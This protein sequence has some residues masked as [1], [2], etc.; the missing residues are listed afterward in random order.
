MNLRIDIARKVFPPQGDAPERRIFESFHLSLTSGEVCAL[1]G[2]SGIGKSSLLQIVAGLAREAFMPRFLGRTAFTTLGALAVGY[3]LAKRAGQPRR[4]RRSSEPEPTF[5][6]FVQ[7]P[8]VPLRSAVIGLILLLLAGPR[9]MQ[10]I[11]QEHA[12]AGATGRETDGR[13]SAPR[14]GSLHANGCAGCHTIP[15][16]AHANGLVGPQL[17]SI[18]RRVNVA[19]MLPNS[20]E[21]LIRWIVNRREVNPKTAIPVTGISEE[22]ARDVAAYLYSLN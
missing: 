6:P 9:D 1:T 17:N 21:N 7:A 16:I 13:R 14:R 22:E 11:L 8:Y 20:P 4:M 12:R 10:P 15:A 3:S 19:G 2:P 18:S 5:A